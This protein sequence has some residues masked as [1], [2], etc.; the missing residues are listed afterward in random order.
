MNTNS[1]NQM[2]NGVTPDPGGDQENKIVVSDNHNISSENNNNSQTSHQ[3]Q[4]QVQLQQQQLQQAQIAAAQ[5]A[6]YSG[7]YGRDVIIKFFMVMLFI[8]HP[9]L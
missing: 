6:Y 8:V 4:N 2:I 3:V 1:S 9:S 7:L 5:N